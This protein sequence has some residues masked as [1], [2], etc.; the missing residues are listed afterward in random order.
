MPAVFGWRLVSVGDATAKEV[1]AGLDVLVQACLKHGE[2]V[3]L[4]TLME[5]P[6]NAL[7]DGLPVEQ[8]RLQ[9]NDLIKVYVAKQTW[10]QHSHADQQ[11]QAEQQQQQQ[12]QPQNQLQQQQQEQQDG[13]VTDKLMKQDGEGSKVVLFD[14]ASALSLKAMGKQQERD[15]CDDG[16][17]L[18]VKGYD[19]MGRLIADA[20]FLHLCL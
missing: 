15:V 13:L 10:M 5:V 3:M 11:P 14:L 6:G 7:P 12:Q 18:T 17:H 4:L 2:S 19:H 16:L 1:M 8:Q 9:L 20:V